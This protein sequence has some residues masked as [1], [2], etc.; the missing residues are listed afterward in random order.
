[1]IIEFVGSTYSVIGMQSKGVA[2]LYLL[3][4]ADVNMYA[5]YLCVFSVRCQLEHTIKRVQMENAALN[6]NAVCICWLC[7]QPSPL[8]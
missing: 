1:M 6:T 8:G 4:K 2:A 7:L 5:S 3:V